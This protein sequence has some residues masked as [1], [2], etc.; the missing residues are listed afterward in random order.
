MKQIAKLVS[1]FLTAL[2]IS[3]CGGVVK[4]TVPTVKKP[5]IDNSRKNTLL[6]SA[7][8]CA[9]NYLKMK[10]YAIKLEKANAICQ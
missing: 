6:G 9:R 8:Q 4:C 10:Q 3:G 5:H 1:V 2:V 7:K